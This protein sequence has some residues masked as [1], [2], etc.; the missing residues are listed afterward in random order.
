MVTLVNRAKVYTTTA[1]TGALTLGTAVAGFQTFSDSGVTNAEILSY[2]LEEGLAWEIGTGAYTTSGTTLTRTLI[3]SSTGA[4]LNLTGAGATVF[5]TAIAS[6]LQLAAEMNQ[7]VATADSPTFVG[8][9]TTGAATIQTLLSVYPLL[10]R[11]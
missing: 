9:T 5:V 11:T 7:S 1:G 2:V 3:Q 4:L 6:D 10:K 8:L